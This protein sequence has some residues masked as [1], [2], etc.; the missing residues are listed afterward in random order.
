VFVIHTAKME[1][2]F[3]YINGC[4]TANSL[5]A[6]RRRK[7]RSMDVDLCKVPLVVVKYSRCRFDCDI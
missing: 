4:L 6:T 7:E 2:G 3:L 5:L 1:V